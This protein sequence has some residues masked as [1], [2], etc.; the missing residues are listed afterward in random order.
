MLG[1]LKVISDFQNKMFNYY[2]IQIH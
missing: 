2:I 1:I